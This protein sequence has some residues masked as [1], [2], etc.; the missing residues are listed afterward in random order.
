MVTTVAIGRLAV[1]IA[2]ATVVTTRWPHLLTNVT[3][4]SKLTCFQVIFRELFLCGIC[5]VPL[6]VASYQVHE[7]GIACLLL[8]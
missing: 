1:A 5:H 3:V 4:L 7:K 6:G 2:V 8:Y